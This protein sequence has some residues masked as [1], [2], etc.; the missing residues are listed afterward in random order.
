WPSAKAPRDGNRP[1]VRKRSISH[2]A[3]ERGRTRASPSPWSRGAG[4]SCHPMAFG[5]LHVSC[6]MRCSYRA[7][8]SYRND[9]FARAVARDATAP[10]LAELLDQPVTER[11]APRVVAP[12]RPTDDV[13]GRCRVGA[14]LERRPESPC[15]PML[16]SPCRRPE[17]SAPAALRGLRRK[18]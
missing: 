18:I 7:A 3:T 15:R 4:T 6:L 13:I 1:E 14:D 11:H 16:L 9:F 12:I 8:G 10:R 2:R 17:R 5:A